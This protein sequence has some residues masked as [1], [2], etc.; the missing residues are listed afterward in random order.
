MDCVINIKNCGKKKS[1]L[2]EIYLFPQTIYY[3]A[4]IVLV[5]K[6][7]IWVSDSGGPILQNP[8]VHP[9]TD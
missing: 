8:N 7:D 4:I 6:K 1:G 2:T 3:P 9:S 5:V